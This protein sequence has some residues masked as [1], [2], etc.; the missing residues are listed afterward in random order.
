MYLSSIRLWNFRKFGGTEIDLEN[1]HLNLSFSKGLNVLIGENDSGKTA[2]ID[3]IKMVL[4]THSLE[5][6][7]IEPED[8]H[9]SSDRFRIEIIFEDLSQHEAK[10]FTEWLGWEGEGEEAKPFLRLIYDAKRNLETGQVLPTDVRAGVDSEGRILT[11]EAKEYLKATYLKPLRD[12]ASELIPKR[13]SRLSQI[14]SGHE[15]FKG[16]HDSH[17]LVDIFA[18]FN[19]SITSYFYGQDKDGQPHQDQKGKDLKD[20]IDQYIKAFYNKGKEAKFDVTE[21][22]LKQ[23]LER[24]ELSIKDEINPGLG[25]LNRLFM[26]SEL[27]HLDKD[28]WHGVHLGLIEELEAHLH[29]QAQMQIIEALQKK[30]TIQLILT[31]HSPNIG[32]K[33]HLHRLILCHKNK[34]YPMGSEYTHLASK[35]YS[36]LEIFLDTTKANLFFAKGIILVEGWSEEILI[37]LL[38][39]KIGIDLTERGVSVVNVGSTAFLRYAKIYQRKSEGEILDLPVAIVTDSDVDPDKEGVVI[40]DITTIEK[41][42]RDKKAKYDGGSVKTFVSPHKTLELCLYKSTSTSTLLKTAVEKVH[43]RIDTV[44][45]ENALLQKMKKKSLKKTEIARRIAKALYS[46]LQKSPDQQK[47]NIDFADPGIQ[48]LIEAIKY[49]S[50]N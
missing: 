49:A 20:A 23:I 31:T 48:Y 47:V 35:D 44:N 14:L 24:L 41:V 1:P 10:N 30:D 21:G 26:A 7:R 18:E 37:P 38:A 45:F 8:F 27:L 32:S 11:A 34:V 12:A 28:S 43:S 25:T 6:F 3:A 15:A 42:I 17:S 9:D 2:I 16:K 29:P 50:Q 39:K 33:V 40:G 19:K 13:N 46:D 36:F 4:K 22:K 5:W